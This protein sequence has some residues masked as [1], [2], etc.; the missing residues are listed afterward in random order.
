MFVPVILSKMHVYDNLNEVVTG[1]KSSSSDPTIN[2]D[3]YQKRHRLELDTAIKNNPNFVNNYLDRADSENCAG[4]K[5]EWQKAKDDFSKAIELD[6]KSER[7]Y[8]GR[9]IVYSNL[10][11]D[12]EA[13]ADYTKAIE[14][15]HP[16][17][18]WFR[19]T[20]PYLYSLRGALYLKRHE[21]GSAIAD[22]T[23]AIEKQDQRTDYVSRAQAYQESGDYQKALADYQKAESSSPKAPWPTI[24]EKLGN[25]FLKLGEKEKAILE[26]N[27]AIQEYDGQSMTSGVKSEDAQ[28]CRE[29]LKTLTDSN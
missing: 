22:Y 10:Q 7:A 5:S 14:C 13:I 11:M 16:T 6:P 9:A 18:L 1:G 19:K 8:V 24:H 25:V 28:K 20:S 12:E 15:G 26:L 23:T 3:E 29:I 2:W 4:D 21:Y 17:F 27:T